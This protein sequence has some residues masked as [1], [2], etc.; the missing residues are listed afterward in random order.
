MTRKTTKFCLSW[1]NKTLEI[2]R[3]LRNIAILL[4][5]RRIMS[6]SN[7]ILPLIPLFYRMWRH[8][9]ADDPYTK[10]VPGLAECSPLYRCSYV[11]CGRHVLWRNRIYWANHIMC[12]IQYYI[13][14]QVILA[15]WLV[16]AYDL[17]ED[18]CTID[19]MTT[20][21]FPQCFKM[22]ERIENLDH[23]LHDWTKVKYKK[24]LSRH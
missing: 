22:A 6:H 5:E 2:S 1:P 23:I 9:L 20:K 11:L 4:T 7:L 24:I 16:L 3:R 18:R 21:F 8:I 14:A 19:V 17:L 10:K 13:I 12:S 15:F